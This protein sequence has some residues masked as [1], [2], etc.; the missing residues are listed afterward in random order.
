MWELKFCYFFVQNL[1]GH[2]VPG[3]YVH[4]NLWKMFNSTIESIVHSGISFPTDAQFHMA[5]YSNDL[6]FLF[7]NCKRK[8]KR[9]ESQKKKDVLHVNSLPVNEQ[10]QYKNT[11]K[12]KITSEVAICRMNASSSWVKFRSIP[13]KNCRYKRL[14]SDSLVAPRAWK[15]ERRTWLIL[16]TMTVGK[17]TSWKYILELVKCHWKCLLFFGIICL[18]S[19]FS[20]T[21]IVIESWPFDYQRTAQF[22]N[23]GPSQL[24]CLLSD[25]DPGSH[26]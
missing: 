9:I 21:I 3:G 11:R 24:F 8:Y 4:G 12:R 17:N 15:S 16:Q 23:E 5:F 25:D 19:R 6:A 13:V 2:L 1:L 10:T 18:V 26:N 7:I 22:S 14:M 20:L